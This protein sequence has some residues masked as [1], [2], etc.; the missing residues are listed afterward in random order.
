MVSVK[1]RGKYYQYTFDVAKIGGKR[2]QKSRS[3]FKTKAEAQKIA[4]IKHIAL[5]EAF[6]KELKYHNADSY[7]SCSLI[8][9][10]CKYLKS[11]N[12]CDV[13]EC[14]PYNCQLKV[15]AYLFMDIFGA[16]IN[17]F[18]CSGIGN[19]EGELY[20]IS[21]INADIDKYFETYPFLK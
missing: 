20:D 10:R 1:K 5:L 15:S 13:I 12:E 7:Y 18:R 2:R 19:P 21:E 14:L 6:N 8:N 11:N 4:D 3:G 17:F 16:G 9:G